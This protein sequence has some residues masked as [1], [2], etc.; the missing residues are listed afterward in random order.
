MVMILSI[1][2]SHRK[3]IVI[4]R[5]FGGRLAFHEKIVIE[6]CRKYND[7]PASICMPIFELMYIWNYFNMIRSK[8]DLLERWLQLIES[9]SADS[10][11]VQQRLP[12]FDNIA[13]MW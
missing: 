6:R 7:D 2:S 9:R 3:I 1:A 5:N 11:S 4:K 12:D 8:P 13:H 10:T